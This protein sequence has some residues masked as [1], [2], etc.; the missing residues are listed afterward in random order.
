MIKAKDIFVYNLALRFL[1]ENTPADDSEKIIEQ[2]LVAPF[3]KD[4]HLDINSLYMRLLESA[5]NANMK[6]GVVGGSI[7]GVKNLK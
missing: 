2:Y 1:K 5:Q 6:A 7:D 3:N 4:E